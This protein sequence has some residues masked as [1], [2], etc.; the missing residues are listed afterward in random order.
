MS[1][2]P[3]VRKFGAPKPV[4]PAEIARLIAR[5]DK[6][7]EKLSR[8]RQRVARALIRARVRKSA[9]LRLGND[10]ARANLDGAE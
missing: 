9:L 3:K 1:A 10:L 2:P 7:I 4:P 6:R 5:E 8:E